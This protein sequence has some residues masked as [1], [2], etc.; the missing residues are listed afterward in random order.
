MR[1]PGLALLTE[2]FSRMRWTLLGI[3]ASLLF[4]PWMLATMFT[5]VAPLSDFSVHAIFSLII[6][7]ECCIPFALAAGQ[8]EA[9]RGRFGL[10]PR[11]YALPVSAARLVFWQMLPG[12]VFLAALHLVLALWLRILTGHVV[13][14][15]EPAMLLATLYACAAAV[16]WSLTGFA[17][18]RMVIAFLVCVPLWWRLLAQTNIP[19]PYIEWFYQ[20]KPRAI[21][22]AL[23]ALIAASYAAAVPGVARD[24]RGE[25][26]TLPE[27]RTLA[28]LSIG[29]LPLRRRRFASPAAAQLWLEWRQ[30][31]LIFPICV[32][33]PTTLILVIQGLFRSFELEP[34]LMTLFGMAFYIFIPG[35][36]VVGILM[37]QMDLE[38]K[39]DGLD[40][41]RATR[42]LSDCAQATAI[43][44]TAALSLVAG[45]VVCVVELLAGIGALYLTGHAAVVRTGFAKWI[46]EFGYPALGYWAMPIFLFAM[47]LPAWIVLSL[48][49]IL[50]L[51][52]HRKL[53][54]FLVFGVLLVAGVML[55][56]SLKDPQWGRVQSHLALSV[57]G[58]AALLG[59]VAGLFG[60]WRRGLIGDRMASIS[61]VFWLL[62][63]GLGAWVIT[64]THPF[65]NGGAP[66]TIFALGVL[67]LAPS[68]PAL[69]TLAIHWN[70]HR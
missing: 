62:L 23:A 22:P 24:R 42:P 31:G 40:L 8:C 19:L 6:F 7:I 17:F 66:I 63:V 25:A 30:K 61:S 9:R 49:I 48:S 68:T 60:A 51:A 52:G 1:S 34:F 4:F 64:A 58:G 16:I 5:S 54:G 2:F 11:L 59:T 33:L 45:W 29:L 32:L 67:S 46:V 3:L 70:R 44:K 47:L 38:G 12:V 18:L 50:G 26:G 65:P 28:D 57:L 69:G 10:P 43:L 15:F 13:P 14:T 20:I 27:F 55:I 56:L 41:F 53:F 36:L 21:W 39:K 37:G 35:S